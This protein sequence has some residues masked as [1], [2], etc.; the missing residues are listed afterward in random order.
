MKQ[1][2]HVV[3]DVQVKHC[4]G[5]ATQVLLAMLTNVFDEHYVGVTHLLVTTSKKELGVID[6]V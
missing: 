4:E 5:Q 2:W 6:G 3:E 1:L